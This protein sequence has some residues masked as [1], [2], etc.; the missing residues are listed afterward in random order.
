MPL[1]RV[2]TVGPSRGKDGH[3]A[4][5]DRLEATRRGGSTS[6]ARS[7]PRPG[8][9]YLAAEIRT[10]AD[11]SAALRFAVEGAARVYL[12]GA[13]VADVAGTRP[14]GQALEL[15]AGRHSA[16]PPFPTSPGST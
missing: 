9:A 2:D 14:I 5:L 11:Q 13:R 7:G 8:R 1:D 16:P 10:A 12:N 15:R 4:E 6:G 3:R